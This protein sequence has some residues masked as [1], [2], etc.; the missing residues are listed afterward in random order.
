MTQETGIIISM[1][2]KML[3]KGI[4]V[5]LVNIANAFFKNTAS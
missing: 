4:K 3:T 2:P 5:K 1:Q